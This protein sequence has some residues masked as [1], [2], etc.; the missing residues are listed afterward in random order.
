NRVK[1]KM[2]EQTRPLLAS[3]PAES[4]PYITKELTA[5]FER[6][7]SAVTAELA[8]VIKEEERGIAQAVELNQRDQEDRERALGV[9]TET[10]TALVEHR[11]ALQHA[12]LIARQAG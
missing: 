7:E 2:L 1:A 4:E 9:L 11:K 8:E 12:L 3:M 6:V 10:A 5:F